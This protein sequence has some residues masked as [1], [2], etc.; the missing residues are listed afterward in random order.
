MAKTGISMINKKNML[1]KCKI[2]VKETDYK[3]S[4][5]ERPVS[6]TFNIWKH[7]S[8]NIVLCSVK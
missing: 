2:I 5:I 6:E 3:F 7:R 8:Q 1:M 4:P